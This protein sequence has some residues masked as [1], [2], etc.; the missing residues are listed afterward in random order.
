MK[1][2]PCFFSFSLADDERVKQIQV[3]V[4]EAFWDG[5]GWARLA[6]HW[7][8]QQNIGLKNVQRG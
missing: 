8:P 4:N 6:K 5:P 7:Q 1:E 3:R 2:K